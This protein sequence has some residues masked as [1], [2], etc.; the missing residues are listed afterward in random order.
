MPQI[1]IEPLSKNRADQEHQA[2]PESTLYLTR[3]ESAANLDA[4]LQ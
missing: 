3:V 4:T 1:D 2:Q